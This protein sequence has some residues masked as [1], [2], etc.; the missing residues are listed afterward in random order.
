MDI[1]DHFT[2]GPAETSAY[3]QMLRIRKENMLSNPNLWRAVERLAATLMERR[4]IRGEEATQI[5]RDAFNADL[6][7]KNPEMRDQ[8]LA[9]AARLNRKHKTSASRRSSEK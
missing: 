4:T 5:I 8:D 6:Y 9:L 3:L 2:S 1:L 7:A